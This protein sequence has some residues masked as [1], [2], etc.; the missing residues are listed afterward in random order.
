MPLFH[1]EIEKLKRLSDGRRPGGERGMKKTLRGERSF[2][3]IRNPTIDILSG[4]TVS[5]YGIIV[6]IVKKRRHLLI[7][8]SG[9]PLNLCILFCIMGWGLVVQVRNVSNVRQNEEHH[10]EGQDAAP[11]PTIVLIL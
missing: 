1:C 2:R 3:R 10:H 7:L 9:L 11:W 8:R 5:D 6:N 4:K